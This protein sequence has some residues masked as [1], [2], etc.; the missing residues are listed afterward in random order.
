VALHRFDVATPVP[1]RV[2]RTRIR[3]TACIRDG[4]AAVM[5]EE[6]EEQQQRNQQT[7][8]TMKHH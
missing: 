4:M 5:M 3:G 7:S 1:A 8:T 6:A 2:A